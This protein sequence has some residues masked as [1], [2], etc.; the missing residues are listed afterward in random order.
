M[1][2]YGM[3]LST[4]KG[5]E[6]KR[7]ITLI[8]FM[9]ISTTA[10]GFAGEWENS[11]VISKISRGDIQVRDVKIEIYNMAKYADGRAACGSS[12][13]FRAD[14]SV[15]GEQIARWAVSP[16][17]RHPG[18]DFVGIYTPQYSGHTIWNGSFRGA[19]YISSNND[20]MPWATY[21]K[22]KSRNARTGVAFHCGRVTGERESHGCIRMVCNGSREINGRSGRRV[23]AQLL[24]SWIKLAFRNG[25]TALVW[26]EDTYPN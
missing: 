1:T 2:N 10:F 22:Y 25:G 17:K 19:G 12:Q 20:P 7:V 18:T 4:V 5:R 9:L 6:M 15:N 8:V 14:I 16:G 21:M 24:Q 23:D 11:D 13:C 26:T 3:S